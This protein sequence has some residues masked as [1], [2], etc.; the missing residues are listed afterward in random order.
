MEVK[1]N[2]HDR[3]LEN[4]FEYK[5]TIHFLYETIPRK[6]DDQ[7]SILSLIQDSLDITYLYTNEFDFKK[8]FA[9]YPDL[10]SA[11]IDTEIEAYKHW[12]QSGKNEG[13]CAGIIGSQ[14]A[15]IGFEWESYLAI[16]DDLNS[17]GVITEFDAYMHWCMNGR[18]DNRRVTQITGLKNKTTTLVKIDIIMDVQIFNK[19]KYNKQWVKILSDD[20]NVNLDWKYYL[21]NYEDLDKADVKNQ[22][23]AFI[24]WVS[25]GKIEGRNG[26][27]SLAQIESEKKLADMEKQRLADQEKQR[28]VELEKQR[29][30]ELEKQRLAELEKKRLAELEK[31]RLAELEKQR[32]AKIER[33]KLPMYIINLQERI[34]KKIDMI[35]QLKQIG[36][37]DYTFF[38]ACD[39]N[40]PIVKEK[41]EYYET[42]F[43]ERKIRTVPF[44]YKSSFKVIKS[45]G[46]V[47]LIQSTIEL[48]KQIEK[49]AQDYVII[50][51]DDA[52]FHKA[53][54]YMLKPIR[55]LMHETDMVYLGYNSHIPAINTMIVNDDTKIIE[56]IPK[57]DKLHTLYGTYG[58]ICSSKFRRKIIEIGIDWFIKNNCTIDFGYNVLFRDGTLT[59]AIPTGEHLIIPDVFDE[60][61]INGDRKN[62]ES[63]YK[64][65]SIQLDNYHALLTPKKRF[66]FIV[67]SYNNEEWISRNLRSMFNQTYSNWRMI[68][69][70]DFST[71]STHNKFLALSGDY[72]NKITYLNNTKKYGQAFNRYRAYNMCDDDEMCIMLDGDDWLSS[73]YVLSYLNKFIQYYDVDMTY[74]KFDVYLN[75]EITPYNVPCDFSQ[76]VIENCSYRSDIW[77]SCHLRTMKA[78]L[79]KQIRPTDIFDEEGEFIICSTDMVESF[80]CLELSNGRHK[81]NPEVCM[82]YNKENSVNFVST[83]HYSDT[84]KEKKV[85]TQ[86]FV[87]DLPK[88]KTGRCMNKVFVLDVD[89]ALFKQHLANYR[90]TR[91]DTDDLFVCKGHD[92]RAYIDKINRYKDVCYM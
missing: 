18:H 41:Y 19:D 35:N 51:E 81:L 49:N 78:S 90:N 84:N 92:M 70:N 27:K 20:L 21:N 63:F 72:S 80:A 31:K 15:Y 46:A 65:R 13:R 42:A 2:N 39:K 33:I 60:D 28:L 59:G 52:Q 56:K 89:S 29:F 88:Y 61:A 43:E 69:I 48:F 86:K 9:M 66:V 64:D 16:N 73:K 11:G 75:N 76:N 30:A 57:N 38:N 44:F 85:A 47:G 55:L 6:R 34:D 87:R 36:Y 53:F 37:T 5:D 17:I 79:L 54:K 77:R 32:L 40:T 82:I 67:P 4:G 74:G 8:Y 58:Y 23:T 7:S 91:S 68:Y 25:H 24:H 62:K 1:K 50:C 26:K 14:D 12:I 3:K 83:S 71:D 45:I 22:Y 10:K